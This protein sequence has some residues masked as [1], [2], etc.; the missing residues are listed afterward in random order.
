M[1]RYHDALCRMG[2]EV[3]TRIESTRHGTEW[4]VDAFDPA[5][6]EVVGSG[7]WR[8]DLNTA[9]SRA[10]KAVEDLGRYPIEF[11]HPTTERTRE[12]DGERLRRPSFGLISIHRV[13]GA[14]DLYGSSIHH[15]EAIAI[16]V[17]TSTYKRDLSNDW[18]FPGDEVVQLYMSPAQWASFVSSFN[19]G[20]G[21]PC[22]LRW[23]Q[24]DRSIE[25]E[26]ERNRKELFAE[27][28]EAKIKGATDAAAKLAKRAGELL[29]RPGTLT[30]AEK[31]ELLGLMGHIVQDIRSNIPFVEEQFREQ[32]EKTVTEASKEIEAIFHRIIEH[33]GISALKDGYRPPALTAGSPAEPP[34]GEG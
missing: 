11:D 2:L 27:E 23:T 15:T 14:F 16:T 30:K 10:F 24:K 17:S 34:Q 9:C 28:F 5:T 8:G 13:N 22:T 33:T 21:I 1:N 4:L 31:Q 12:T 19:M 29:N 26:P 20:G 6:Q 18:Y 7:K 25:H 32:M 3:R